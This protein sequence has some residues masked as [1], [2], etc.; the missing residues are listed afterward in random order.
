MDDS[1][2]T[3][4]EGATG[5]IKGFQESLQGETGIVAALIFMG[6]PLLFALSIEMFRGH[7]ITSTA[8]KRTF[9]VQC[10]YFAPLY[11]SM[12]SFVVFTVHFYAVD[13]NDTL[14]ILVLLLFVILFV[15]FVV[16]EIR[17]ISRERAIGVTKATFVFLLCVVISL[18]ALV[19]SVDPTLA[20]IMWWGYL[21][22][23]LMV[24]STGVF[25]KKTKNGQAGEGTE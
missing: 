6:L 7:E 8:L 5:G 2:R 4:D 13:V 19:L 20:F 11:L 15:W 3:I 17:T 18:L 1:P 12:W 10:Y 14:M 24:F 21:I 16:N 23:A 9:Y 22:A 25:S